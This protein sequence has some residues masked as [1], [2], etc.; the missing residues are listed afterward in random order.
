MLPLRAWCSPQV[1]ET[2]DDGKPLLFG[3]ALSCGNK[4]RQTIHGARRQGGTGQS[5]KSDSPI[6]TCRHVWVDSVPR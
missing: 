1:R 5:E 2:L 6:G 4:W 3:L